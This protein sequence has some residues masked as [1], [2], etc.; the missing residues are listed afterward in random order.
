MSEDEAQSPAPIEPAGTPAETLPESPAQTVAEPG[1]E[2]SIDPMMLMAIG[3]ILLSLVV[4]LRTLHAET[5]WLDD[6]SL[7][8]NPYVQAVDGISHFWSSAD[9]S[10]RFEPMTLTSYWLSFRVFRDNLAG[11]HLVNMLLHA[12]VVVLLWTLLRRLAVPGALFAAALFAVHPVHAQAVAWISGR[13]V[14]LAS[15]FY[16]ASMLVYLRFLGLTFAPESKTLLTLPPEPERL[17]GL[18]LILFIAALLSS[19]ATAITFPIA[20]LLILWWKRGCPT[21]R[22]LLGLL[23]FFLAAIGPVSGSRCCRRVRLQPRHSRRRWAR[24][25]SSIASPSHR[26][27]SAFMC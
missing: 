24:L 22:E 5:T 18:A 9:R 15:G 23:P 8:D 13:S 19:A 6:V 3:L 20:V 4:F 7:T 2:L 26:G 16:L 10:G 12:G 21:V 1:D 25:P 17:W 11:T 14:V 27:Q